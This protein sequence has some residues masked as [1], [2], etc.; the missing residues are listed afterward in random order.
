ME[1]E[2]M[3]SLISRV[4]DGVESSA[5]LPGVLPWTDPRSAEGV[6]GRAGRARTRLVE[7]VWL[8]GR[9]ERFE[10]FHWCSPQSGQGRRRTTGLLSGTAGSTMRWTVSV[11]RARPATPEGAY[12][13]GDPPGGERR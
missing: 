8:A 6:P 10:E 2:D 13:P 3:M 4:T 5:R 11:R 12:R 7:Q 1:V 9:P